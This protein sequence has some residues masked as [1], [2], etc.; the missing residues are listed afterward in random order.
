MVHFQLAWLEILEEYEYAF[1]QIFVVS[2]SLS[3]LIRISFFQ[4][5]FHFAFTHVGPFNR[6]LISSGL[7]FVCLFCLFAC[8]FS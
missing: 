4:E 3:I 1:V 2:H 7:L 8:F 5:R 6:R